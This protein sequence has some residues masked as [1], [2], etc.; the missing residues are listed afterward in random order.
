MRA[1]VD[2]GTPLSLL[3][4]NRDMITGLIG[5]NAA[6]AARCSIP[7]GAMRQPA[8]QCARQPGRQPFADRRRRVMS[9]TADLLIYCPDPPAYYGMIQ[10]DG[11]GR[12]MID[13]TDVDKGKV[14]VGTPMRMTFRIK[15]TMRP[16]AS[17]GTSGRR[18]RSPRRE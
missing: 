10:F 8:V 12:M 7:G 13:F 6:R 14:E 4:R 15:D 2:K 1:E 9:F 18:R 3:Y 11:G 17:C 5:G 16:A